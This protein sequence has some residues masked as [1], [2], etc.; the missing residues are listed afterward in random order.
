[1]AQLNYS[2]LPSIN[3]LLNSISTCF[4]ILGFI[5]IKNGDRVGH[6]KMM[7]VALV[8]S[9]LFLLSY[10]IYHE[11]VGSV[12]YPFHDWT[13]TLY[14]T[15]LIPHVIL[16]A[17]MVP[18]IIAAVWHA[19]HGNFSKHKHLTRWVWWVWM[20]VSISGVTIYIMLYRP[21]S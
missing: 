9:I 16:A 4:L 6:K 10:L 2:D 15:I 19:F 8:S 21:F 1:M 14:F 12:P 18:F 20:F 7:L 13:R 3:A 5:R 17:G 11:K